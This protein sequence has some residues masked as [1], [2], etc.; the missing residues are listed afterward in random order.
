MSDLKDV[1]ISYSTKD[2]DAKNAL[3]N[4]FEKEGI[5]YFLDE[6]DLQIMQDLEEKILNGLRNTRFTVFLVSKNSLE[7][8]WVAMETMFSLQQNYVTA[9]NRLICTILEKSIFDDEFPIDLQIHYNTQ[10]EKYEGLRQKM[11]SIQG[12]TIVYDKNIQRLAKVD[13]GAIMDKIR[14]SLS[15]IFYDESRKEA[16]LQKLFRTIK[17]AQPKKA[18]TKG[19]STDAPNLDIKAQALALI[20]NDQ[21]DDVFALFSKNKDVFKDYQSF[22]ERYMHDYTDYKNSEKAHFKQSLRVFVDSKKIEN[23]QVSSPANTEE[24]LKEL[25]N[26]KLYDDVFKELYKMYDRMD[27]MQKPLYHQLKQEFDFG[28][29]NFQFA[30]RLKSFISGLFQ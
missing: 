20:D 18:P 26:R 9:E 12:N 27:G 14:S 2:Q 10:K 7:S 6:M 30:T 1:F 4:L 25:V 19:G 21:Y 28:G 8:A 3:V 17:D 24:E 22:R 13:V 11:K 16:D 5:T 29:V 15:V 23:V